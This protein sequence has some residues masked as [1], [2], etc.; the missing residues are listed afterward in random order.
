MPF[1]EQ[2][3]G[4]RLGCTFYR[5]DIIVADIQIPRNFENPGDL[6]G[7]SHGDIAQ[8]QAL[9]SPGRHDDW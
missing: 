8:I 2:P 9:R 3:W 7:S 5:N 4:R 6:T 1:S